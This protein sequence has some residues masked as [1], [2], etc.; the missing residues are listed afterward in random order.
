M[1][2]VRIFYLS[3]EGPKVRLRSFEAL[4]RKEAKQFRW[5]L[6]SRHRYHRC[7]RGKPL[8][9][10]GPQHARVRLEL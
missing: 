6:R 10:A 4:L 1:A 5:T 7:K 2:T 8:D 9:S 3:P